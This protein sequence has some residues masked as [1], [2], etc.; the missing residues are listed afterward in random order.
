[1]SNMIRTYKLE[2]GTHLKQLQ[3]MRSERSND[4]THRGNVQMMMIYSKMCG[5]CHVMMP[6]WEKLEHDI[7]DNVYPLRKQGNRYCLLRVDVDTIPSIRDNDPVMHKKL[8]E[9]L[10]HTRGGV[11]SIAL[12]SSAS[13]KL[14]PYFGERTADSMKKFLLENTPTNKSMSEKSTTKRSTKKTTETDTKSKIKGKKDTKKEK[15]LLEKAKE[16]RRKERIRDKIDKLKEEIKK[17]KE[18]L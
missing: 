6:E 10:T 5:H 18:E 12:E 13:K 16:Q 17:L 8:L 9:M 1:M 14:V 2:P 4:K 15:L 3:D 7:K 11:P